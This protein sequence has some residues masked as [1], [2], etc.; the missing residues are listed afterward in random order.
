LAAGETDLSRVDGVIADF[1]EGEDRAADR[2]LRSST[3]VA[4]EF[5][6][7]CTEDASSHQAP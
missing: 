5:R 6:N 3:W 2:A 7:C 1:G 4:V